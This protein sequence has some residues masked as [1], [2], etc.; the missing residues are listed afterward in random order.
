[1][2]SFIVGNTISYTNN[3]K[4]HTQNE[5]RICT[6]VVIGL[7]RE[8]EYVQNV[9]AGSIVLGYLSDAQS[10]NGTIHVH[11]FKKL[12]KIQ[13]TNTDVQRIL[14]KE[15]KYMTPCTGMSRK[16]RK[17]YRLCMGVKPATFRGTAGAS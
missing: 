3:R 14:Q 10:M 17:L 1:V 12:D 4:G 16:C 2:C 13:L 8:C 6:V 9:E 11:R 7:K 15:K 5:M